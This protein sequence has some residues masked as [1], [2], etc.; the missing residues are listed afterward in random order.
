MRSS[1]RVLLTC[2]YL[3]S[4][5]ATPANAG[6][7]NGSFAVQIQLRNPLSSAAPVGVGGSGTNAYASCTSLTLSQATNAIVTV[8]CGDNQFVSIAPR[9]GAPFLGT[10]GGAYRFLFEPGA[11]VSSED[12]L[13]HVGT[14]TVATLRIYQPEKME[15]PVEIEVSF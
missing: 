5:W 6:T 1:S 7:I 11:P 8:T 13:W 4:A 15:Y 12:P 2:A 10:H 9:A 14:G 3:L